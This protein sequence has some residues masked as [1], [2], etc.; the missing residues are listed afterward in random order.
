MLEV[1]RVGDNYCKEWKE[2]LLE[3]EKRMGGSVEE[4]DKE[5]TEA[6]DMKSPGR[7]VLHGDKK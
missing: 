6:E 2:K 3:T 7:R 5:D 4:L 1:L